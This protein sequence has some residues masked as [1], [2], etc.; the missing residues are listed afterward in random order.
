MRRVCFENW[1]GPVIDSD[2]F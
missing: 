2:L 1:R